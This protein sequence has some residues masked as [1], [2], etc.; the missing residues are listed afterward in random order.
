MNRTV[1]VSSSFRFGV[2]I[3]VDLAKLTKDPQLDTF[4]LVVVL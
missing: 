3:Q 2:I 1:S 4:R